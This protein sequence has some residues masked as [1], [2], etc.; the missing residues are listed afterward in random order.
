[1]DQSFSDI[2]AKC[3]MQINLINTLRKLWMEHVFWTRSFIISTAAGLGDLPY[4]T[5]RLLRNPGDFADVLRPLYGAD[6]AGRFSD[7][8]T[9]HLTIAGSLVN[10]AKAGNTQAANEDRAKWYANANQIA[11]FLASI[12]PYWSQA[13]WQRLLYDHLKITETEAVER[14]TDQ[15]EKDVALFD[16]IED[17]AL[18]MADYMAA[19]IRKQ[20]N[21]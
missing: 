7:L 12:N 14:L 2:S 11:A 6:I 5:R 20:F 21:I 4:V 16:A 19:G 10:N 15:Y 18:M 8:F 1:M 3:K 13:E 9:E 17:Q